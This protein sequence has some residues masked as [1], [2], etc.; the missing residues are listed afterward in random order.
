MN[1]ENGGLSGLVFFTHSF[2][3]LN[4]LQ[5]P[6]LLRQS[7]PLPPQLRPHHHHHHNHHHQDNYHHT[8]PTT[9]TTAFTI[10]LLQL[11]LLELTRIQ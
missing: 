6:P 7:P 5:L 9:T 3:L 4:I 1:V 11:I 10:T 8:T 2:G